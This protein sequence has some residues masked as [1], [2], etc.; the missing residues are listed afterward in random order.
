ML[1]LM[2][3]SKRSHE[4]YDLRMQEDYPQLFAAALQ[5]LCAEGVRFE[6]LARQTLAEVIGGSSYEAL[7]ALMGGDGLNDP[8]VFAKRLSEMLMS[9][10]AVIFDLI[11]GRAV[12]KVPGAR[13]IPE[14]MKFEASRLRRAEAKANILA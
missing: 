10:A 5:A 3:T 11:E 6:P 8:G 2:E 13:S 14:V 7:V 12:E 9:G 1:F 4:L